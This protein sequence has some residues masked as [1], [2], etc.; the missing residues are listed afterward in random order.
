MVPLFLGLNAVNT[1]VL[2][3]VVLAPLL[4]TAAFL[5]EG[6]AGAEFHPALGIFSGFLAALTHTITFTYFMATTKWLEA[7]CVKADLDFNGF[8]AAPRR[9]K[10]R[11]LVLAMTAITITGLAVF[12]GAAADI[13]GQQ[14]SNFAHLHG[15][16]G[17]LAM[18]ANVAC[19]VLQYRHLR[20]RG[21]VMRR[22]IAA[23]VAYRHAADRH[24][25]RSATTV[26]P[27][28]HVGISLLCLLAAAA[29]VRA[30]SCPTESPATSTISAPTSQPADQPASPPTD[31]TL[32]A[33]LARI[34]AAHAKIKSLSAEVTYDRNQIK[35]GDRQRRTGTL[36]Y[37][38]G[39]PTRFAI[40]F[41]HLKVNRR[42]YDQD[43]W[44]IFDGRHFIER[45]DD[46]KQFFRRELVLPGSGSSRMT[47]AIG[48]GP[49][50]VPLPMRSAELQARFVVTLVPPDD[51]TEDQMVHLRLEPR[52]NR[53][54]AVRRIDVWHENTRMIPVKAVTLDRSHYESTVILK[55]ETV[56]VNTALPDGVFRTTAPKGDGWLVEEI[57]YV[58]PEND[59]F[60]S[61][62]TA[63]NPDKDR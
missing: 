13:G 21:A 8:V 5:P 36:V 63:P 51:P 47:L 37:S 23:M 58:P 57:P 50:L 40:H 46:R 27:N 15:T 59:K 10:Q 1:L 12:T 49:F 32:L 35:L 20:T 16:A 60:T 4:R 28:A 54:M 33:C 24:E 62:R 9:A 18:L 14:A 42:R 30:E 45:L 22:A 48:D 25:G 39:P 17:L 26:T 55:A 2:L 56:K 3:A 31:L 7:A 6:L 41:Q 53:R 38:A 44:Y 34:E 11:V 43:R 29:A 61:P 52:P 19:S